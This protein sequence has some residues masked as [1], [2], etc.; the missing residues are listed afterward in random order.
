MSGGRL[1]IEV[2][3]SGAIVNPFEILDAVNKGVVDS[4]QWWT[5]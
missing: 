3:T 5:H 2:L 4:G 1:V